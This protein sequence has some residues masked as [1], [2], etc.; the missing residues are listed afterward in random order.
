MDLNYYFNQFVKIVVKWKNYSENYSIDKQKSIGNEYF[1]GNYK[2][3]I[4]IICN[5]IRNE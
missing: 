2:D 1:R 4:G 3:M 5:C